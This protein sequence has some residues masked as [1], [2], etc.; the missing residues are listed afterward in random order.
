MP[1][2][3]IECDKGHLSEVLKRGGASTA[4]LVCPE[5]KAPAKRKWSDFGARVIATPD[6][7]PPKDPNNRAKPEF[8]ERMGGGK[9]A[10]DE[11]NLYRPALTHHT[12]CPKESWKWRNVAV[13]NDL[14]FAVRLCCEGCGYTWLYQK[15]T[16]AY[17]LLDGVVNRYRPGKNWSSD[18]PAGSGY[19]EPKRGA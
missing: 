1:L 9:A 10:K 2:L 4:P 18:A 5:C 8:I 17:P 13:L 16:A 3:E 6:Y 11:K 14:Q 19:E 15:E 12:K 7:A